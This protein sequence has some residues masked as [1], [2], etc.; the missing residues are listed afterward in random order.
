MASTSFSQRRDTQNE[1]FTTKEI[2]KKLDEV[3]IINIETN[4]RDL[5]V[6]TLKYFKEVSKSYSSKSGDILSNLNMQIE[7]CK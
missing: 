4:E 3:E 5:I 7:V 6:N 1:G 2:T